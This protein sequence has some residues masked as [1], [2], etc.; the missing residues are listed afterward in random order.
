MLFRSNDTAT[1]EIYTLSLHDA[2]P[3][4]VGKLGLQKLDPSG[5]ELWS[6]SNLD[7]TTRIAVD[8]DLNIYMAFNTY[9]SLAYPVPITLCKLDPSGN[10]VW[11]QYAVPNYA[12]NSYDYATDV[13]VDINGYVY[14][15][16]AWCDQPL[17]KLSPGGDVIW[18]NP[19]NAN[20]I[21]A[22]K[23]DNLYVAASDAVYKLDSSGN[24]IYED[25]TES[26]HS[27]SDVRVDS[28]GYAYIRYSG[29]VDLV[30]RKIYC[31]PT[32]Y[33]VRA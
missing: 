2:L 18:S 7:G 10:V 8:D 11:S 14:V 30:V 33:I 31:G 24:T 16:Y 20:R 6:L 17:R 29:R 26:P 23:V 5:N 3:I 15:A 12:R 27:S 1:T 22:N 9:D 21:F 28:A 32:K 25:I 13:T 4:S 19:I